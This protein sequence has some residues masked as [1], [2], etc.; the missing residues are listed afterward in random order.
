ME[1]FTLGCLLNNTGVNRVVA[2][3]VEGTGFEEFGEDEDLY[4][5]A[6]SYH[7]CNS[8]YYRLLIMCFQV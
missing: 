6:G 4:F 3:R 8:G 2:F 7:S 1:L 5:F